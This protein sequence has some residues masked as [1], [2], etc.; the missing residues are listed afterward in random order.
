MWAYLRIGCYKRY[1]MTVS[2]MLRAQ[3]IK[4]CKMAMCST[5]LICFYTDVLLCARLAHVWLNLTYAHADDDA[6]DRNDEC[7]AKSLHRLPK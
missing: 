1:F 3:K 6:F 2:T 7:M 4:N 5:I